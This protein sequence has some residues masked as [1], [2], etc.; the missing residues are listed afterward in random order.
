MDFLTALTSFNQA[1]WLLIAGIVLLFVNII[2]GWVRS[3]RG[4]VKAG[5]FTVGLALVACVMIGFGTVQAASASATAARAGQFPGRGGGFHNQAD[6]K[7]AGSDK[8]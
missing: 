3:A 6:T 7:F 5:W 2:Y 4:S 8:H 1:T